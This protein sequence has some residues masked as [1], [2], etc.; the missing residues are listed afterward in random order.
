VFQSRQCAREAKRHPLCGGVRGFMY[1]GARS[2]SQP[3]IEVIYQIEDHQIVVKSAVF[4]DAK[5]SAAG[6]V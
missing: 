1:D 3:D 5:A 2:I 6:R 4:S